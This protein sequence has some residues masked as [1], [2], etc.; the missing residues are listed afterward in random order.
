M[1]R[2]LSLI[3]AGTLAFGLALTGCGGGASQGNEAGGES[4]ASASGA[5]ETSGSAGTASGTDTAGFMMDVLNA[6]IQTAD[7]Q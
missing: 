6:D 2:K 1:K 3:L 4:S 5:G 7:V